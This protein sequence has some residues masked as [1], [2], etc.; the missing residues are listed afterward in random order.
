MMPVNMAEF[1]TGL[2][3]LPKFFHRESRILAYAAHG[4]SVDGIIA[5]NRHEPAAIR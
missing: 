3:E 5:R 4:E 2:Q 1:S